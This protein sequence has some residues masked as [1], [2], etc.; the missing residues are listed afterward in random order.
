MSINELF[1][2]EQIEA[3]QNGEVISGSLK[4]GV[5]KA[6]VF[7]PTTTTPI[8]GYG[9][10]L[11]PIIRDETGEPILQEKVTR[12]NIDRHNKAAAERAL[13]DLELADA[14][15]AEQA[16]LSPNNLLATVKVLERKIRKIEKQLK[17]Q[18]ST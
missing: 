15:K 1:T 10:D 5:V 14:A 12:P 11:K 9:S 4:D 16:Q 8:S 7:T 6:T 3:L 18:Q 13:K 2:K 17:E